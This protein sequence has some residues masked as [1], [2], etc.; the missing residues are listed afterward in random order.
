MLPESKPAL[1]QE[2]TDL[3]SPTSLPDFRL[4]I[5][6]DNVDQAIPVQI[7]ERNPVHSL[8]NV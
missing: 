5:H 8:A 2:D 4:L 1:I 6:R 7:G 3:R